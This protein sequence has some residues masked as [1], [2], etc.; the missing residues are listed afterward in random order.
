MK[1][2]LSYHNRRF[3]EILEEKTR[4]RITVPSPR[5]RRI[6][7]AAPGAARPKTVNYTPALARKGKSTAGPRAICQAI[8]EYLQRSALVMVP[9]KDIH[10]GNRTE[11]A[12]ND[13]G[14]E[15]QILSPESYNSFMLF[16]ELACLVNQGTLLY[17]G[18]PG[19]SKTSLA[20][21]A[22]HHMYG[23]P[24]QAIER[25]TIKGHEGITDTD[26]LA[27]LDMGILIKEG[28]EVPRARPFVES[29]VRIVDE[30]NRL[31]PQ[32][33][34]IL[35]SI[36][37]D[38]EVEYRGKI[39]RAPPGPLFATANYAD[40]GNSELEEPFLDRLD[41]RVES[42]SLNPFYNELFR[43]RKSKNL[44]RT[45]EGIVGKPQSLTMDDFMQ[46]RREIESVKFSEEAY[47]KFAYFIAEINNCYMA[48][49]DTSKKKKEFANNEKVGNGL[50]GKCHY[51]SGDNLCYMTENEIG[52]RRVRATFNFASGLAWWRGKSEVG[53][54][55]LRAVIPYTLSHKLRPT[56]K[57]IKSDPFYMNDRVAFVAEMFEKA[58]RNYDFVVQ[59][60]P[61]V[62]KLTRMVYETYRHGSQSGIN[63]D[64][65]L[66]KLNNEIPNIDS[67]AKFAFS[68][69]LSDLM[70]MLK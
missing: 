64:D 18:A 32:Q 45:L 70:Y 38:G 22:A 7:R 43:D 61:V 29:M 67:P 26:M 56:E 47:A 5:P 40:A 8:H 52:P 66:D 30:V 12:L 48:R 63:V 46:A 65:V 54:E 6:V 69:A 28:K 51:A 13:S 37:S 31:G 36:A 53:M 16:T 60:A 9:E 57:A 44:Q 2:E 17:H 14:S 59:K 49:K 41:V 19:T 10:F 55:E 42:S 33:R 11:V 23:I 34:N 1:P 35:Y 62:K 39:F 68:T 58:E 4:R 15:K 3:M 21:L 27:M 20:K 24:L 25:A 50:C